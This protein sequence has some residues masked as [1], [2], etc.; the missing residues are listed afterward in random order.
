M[1]YSYYTWFKYISVKIVTKN[2]GEVAIL[3]T[4]MLSIELFE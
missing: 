3:N 4:E 2:K 1:F